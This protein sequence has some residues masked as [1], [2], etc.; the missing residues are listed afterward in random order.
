MKALFLLLVA[1]LVSCA[2]QNTF[3][4]SAEFVEHVYYMKQEGEYLVYPGTVE[5]YHKFKA[6]LTAEDMG[7]NPMAYSGYFAEG[8]VVTDEI[9][10]HNKR[11]I[12]K[13]TK[14]YEELYSLHVQRRR[15]K[16]AHIMAAALQGASNSLAQSQ[17]Q[18]IRNPSSNGCSSDYECGPNQMCASKN[19]LGL[20]TC[21]SVVNKYN[22]PDYGYQKSFGVKKAVECPA[23]GCN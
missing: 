13:I 22:Q 8:G 12:E 19:N 5:E 4:G 7:N 17:E 10:I 20:G 2:S 23:L 14:K 21:M 9:K 16:G 3:R 18:T 6:N 15:Q 1:L 11:I